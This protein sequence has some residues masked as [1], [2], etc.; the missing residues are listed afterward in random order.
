MGASGSS[1]VGQRAGNS[2]RTPPA[3]QCTGPGRGG[4]RPPETRLP[5]TAG[6]SAG[7]AGAIPHGGRTR[8]GPPRPLRLKLQRL[9]VGAEFVGQVGAGQR[10]LDGGLE[11]AELVARVVALALGLHPLPPPALAQTAPPLPPPD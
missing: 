1:W 2:G 5:T 9:E 7:F 6:S 11:K 8:R 10:E 3:S 4:I